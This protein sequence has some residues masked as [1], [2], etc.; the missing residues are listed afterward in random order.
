MYLLY[1]HTN[2]KVSSEVLFL[3]IG[4]TEVPI[5]HDE[6]SRGSTKRIGCRPVSG[7][8]I[9]L[10]INEEDHLTDSKTGTREQ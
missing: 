6:L 9:R 10:Y 1:T 4:Y 5:L 3:S 2:V 8:N 7:I